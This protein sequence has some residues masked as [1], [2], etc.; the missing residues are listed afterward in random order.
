VVLPAYQ[1]RDP[2]GTL[3]YQGIADHLE[4]FLATL[5]ADPTTK[6]L[7]DDVVDAL[8]ASLSCGILTHAFRRLGC[9]SCPHQMLLAF[10]CTKR[11][12]CPSC[13]GR[14]MAQQTA[15]LVEQVIPW[16][17]TRPWVVSL[18]IPL[19]YW[20]APSREA[21]RP[22]PHHHPPHHRAIRRHS[23]GQTGCHTG[24]G[25]AGLSD[26]CTALRGKLASQCTR[27]CHVS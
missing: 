4:T 16:V 3:L 26:V 15:H 7:P 13:A 24:P 10:R 5:A 18:P 12:L 21:H 19:R 22:G 17:P 27:P 14:R 25:A 8:D 6:G 11:G 9:D 2:S 20:M 23:S 1:P